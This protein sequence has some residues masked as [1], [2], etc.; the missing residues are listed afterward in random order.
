MV[1]N[2]YNQVTTNEHDL[3][4]PVAAF[5]CVALTPVGALDMILDAF[6]TVA[7][8]LAYFTAT[9]TVSLTATIGNVSRSAL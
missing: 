1:F 3:F 4:F 5:A 8:T 7:V 2:R 6:T 9:R